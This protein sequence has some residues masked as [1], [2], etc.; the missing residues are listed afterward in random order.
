MRQVSEGLF[1]PEGVSVNKVSTLNLSP[2]YTPLQGDQR[3]SCEHLFVFGNLVSFPEH[4]VK[5]KSFRSTV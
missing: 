4:G 3:H 5:L 1:P 2:I